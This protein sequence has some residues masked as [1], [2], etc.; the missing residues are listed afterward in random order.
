MSSEDVLIT[1]SRFLY[2]LYDYEQAGVC[3]PQLTS[4]WLVGI[5]TQET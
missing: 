5:N 3:Y 1:A 2:V 4:L